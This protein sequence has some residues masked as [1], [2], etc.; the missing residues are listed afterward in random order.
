MG[1]RFL[2]AV[3]WILEVVLVTVV[4][5]A[6]YYQLNGSDYKVSLILLLVVAP[7]LFSIL[8]NFSHHPIEGRK[9]FI[10]L[11]GIVRYIN[12]FF[13]TLSCSVILVVLDYLTDSGKSWNG[14]L[15]LLN[16]ANFIYIFSIS[17]VLLVVARVVENSLLEIEL[18]YK[19][20]I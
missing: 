8:L 12:Y 18:R 13:V 6:M 20:K 5:F 16:D 17:L 11:F 9:K 15:Y 1:N 10:I 14:F 19:I 7:T 3:L 2:Q 4:S